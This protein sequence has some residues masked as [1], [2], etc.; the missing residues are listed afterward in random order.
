MK[1]IAIHALLAGASVLFGTQVSAQTAPAELR[2][3]LPS[4]TLAGTAKLIYWGFDVYNASLWVTPGFKAAQYERHA[5]ALELAYLRD[6]SNE[7]ISRRS[8]DEMRRQTPITDAQ[9]RQ[10]AQ[11]LR[12]AF[13]NVQAGDRIAG[14]NRP[15]VG[16]LFLTNGQPTGEIR[17]PGFARLF[18]GIW[19]APDTSEPALRRAL[20]AQVAQT[21][22]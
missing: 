16:A 5:F 13:P 14:V 20:L 17:D 21:A 6:F 11:A 1:R 7:D 12:E 3:A 8:L 15:G 4:A 18:F 22:P 2:A 19:L 10:W 9:A